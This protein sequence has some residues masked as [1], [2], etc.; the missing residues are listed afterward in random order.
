METS[1]NFYVSLISKNGEEKN[2]EIGIQEYFVLS[3]Y[4]VVGI[5]S[6]FV[7]AFVLLIF[8]NQLSHKK[9]IYT[10][11]KYC[12]WYEIIISFHLIKG[13][14]NIISGISNHL[15]CKIDSG[16][17]YYAMNLSCYYYAV[18]MIILMYTKGV[19]PKI[20]GLQR[21]LISIPAVL[22]AL[23]SVILILSN[24]ISGMTTW[25][26][27]FLGEDIQFFI[28]I[29]IYLALS[30]VFFVMVLLGKVELKG[31]MANFHYFNLI[32][33]LC[34]SV[35]YANYFIDNLWG[36]SLSLIFYLL[37]VIVFRLKIDAVNHSFLNNH[38]SK[39]RFIF[40]IATILCID[41]PPSESTVLDV[42][43]DQKKVIEEYERRKTKKIN[44][45]RKSSEGV[46]IKEISSKVIQ[47]QV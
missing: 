2:F 21:T 5:A 11:F 39:N 4:L 41:S 26:T 14:I 18:I 31:I 3:L 32:N 27:C 30:I 46:S 45:M 36:G 9:N 25:Y 38:I 40:F 44:K 28:G 8:I 42:Q 29:F 20:S 17:T 10:I 33:T 34:F 23:V 47:D 12:M 22:G 6:I 19:F 35:F 13:A 37:N 43:E 24:D 1:Y 7:I 15:V 16:I